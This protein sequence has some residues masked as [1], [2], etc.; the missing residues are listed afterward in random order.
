VI[1][2]K[3]CQVI[4]LCQT[5]PMTTFLLALIM[6]LSIRAGVANAAPQQ[7]TKGVQQQGEAF[8]WVAGGGQSGP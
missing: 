2:Q 8:N 4:R 1:R 7:R 5:K 3:A 6:M